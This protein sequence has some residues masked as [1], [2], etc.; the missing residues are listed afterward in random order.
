M[1][2]AAFMGEANAAYYAAGDPLGAAGDFIT[3]PEISQMF[4]EM[5]GLC[6]ADLWRRKGSPAVHYVELGPGRGTLAVDALRT[7]RRFGLAP[8]VHFVET[9]PAL[10][11]KQGAAVAD[12]RWHDALATLPR[13]GPLLVVA[14]EF[15]D[16]LP[17]RQFVKTVAGWRERMVSVGPDGFV[18]V[19]GTVPCDALIPARL[20]AAEPGSIVEASPAIAAVARTLARRLADQG[21]AALIVDYGYADRAA[22][23]TLQAVHAHAYADPIA[24]PG[25]SDLTA[26]VDFGALAAAAEGVAALGPVDQGDWLLGL[27]IG[28]RAEALAAASPTRRDEILAGLRRLT[29]GDEMGTLFKILALVAPDWPAPAGFD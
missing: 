9:S 25:R 26:H 27:G 16:A 6:L 8:P 13:D 3:A 29:A 19:P 14:N 11:A 24:A 18:P 20:L 7:M 1:S 15:F 10:R 2:L 4:G 12:A 21:G 22:G 5:I 23:D 17:I 28:T